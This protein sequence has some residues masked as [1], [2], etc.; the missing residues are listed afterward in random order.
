MLRRKL[1]IG[2]GVVLIAAMLF[3]AMPVRTA[4]S[5]VN[6]TDQ[7]DFLK[8]KE[9]QPGDPLESFQSRFDSF[10]RQ[11]FFQDPSL[12]N[13]RGF[14]LFNRNINEHFERIF[15]NIDMFSGMNFPTSLLS[16]SMMQVDKGK[17][18]IKEIDD[19][20]LVK[21]DLPG[22]DKNS[23]DL[24]L[25]DNR[26]IISSERKQTTT[27]SDDRIRIY[28]NEISYGSFSRIVDLPQPVIEDKV[29]ASYENGVLTVIAP[30]NKNKPAKDPGRKIEIR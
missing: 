16:N 12:N 11:P 27:S 4:E 17:A 24:K 30:I 5:G 2:F 29:E 23:I 15:K 20:L 9:D 13:L 26:L 7:D 1:I 10:M 18:E 22:L 19:K 6:T 3:F 28:R 21:L 14:D 25:S 8:P